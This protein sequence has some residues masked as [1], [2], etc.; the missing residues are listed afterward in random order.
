M[1]R[2]SQEM[3][4]ELESDRVAVNVLSPQGGINTPGVLFGQSDP[5]NPRLDFE[6]GGLGEFVE[7]ELGIEPAVVFAT[8]GSTGGPPHPGPARP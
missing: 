6:T 7:S 3:A 4:I 1:E 8:S 2:L 5:Q